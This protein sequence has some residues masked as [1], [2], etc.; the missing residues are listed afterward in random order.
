MPAVTPRRAR[1]AVGGPF[2]SARAWARPGRRATFTLKSLTFKLPMI[3]PPGPGPPGPA[4]LAARAA[5]MMT[6]KLPG[7]SLSVES[8]LL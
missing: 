1:A 8:D 7:G 4:G 6:V 3:G 5:M 2:P